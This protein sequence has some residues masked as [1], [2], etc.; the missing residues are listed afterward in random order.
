MVEVSSYLRKETIAEQRE[1]SDLEGSS[2]P[3]VRASPLSEG[4]TDQSQTLLMES[5]IMSRSPQVDLEL[6]CMSSPHHFV[7]PG[8]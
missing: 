6:F 7:V 2:A 3:N 1:Q 4:D 8:N 5:R